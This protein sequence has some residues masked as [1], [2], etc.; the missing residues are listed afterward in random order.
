MIHRGLSMTINEEIV[1]AD[2]ITEDDGL[3]FS[4]LLDGNGG[5]S[6]V[7][8][9]VVEHWTAEQG[10]IWIHLD[11]MSPR[12]VNWL[13]ELSGLTKITCD[14][15]L[16]EETRPRVFQGKR[17]FVAILRGVNLNLDANLEDLITLRLWSDGQ[18]VISVRRERLQTP[19]D[20][21]AQLLELHSGPSTASELYERLI[22]RLNERM[23]VATG[24]IGER[25]DEFE[26]TGDTKSAADSRREIADLRSQILFLRRYMAPQRAA[27]HQLYLEPPRWLEE[28]SRL[29]LREASDSM[30]RYV[31]DLDMSRERATVI[32]DDIAS[33]LSESLNKN[34]YMLSIITALFLPISFGTGLL[35]INVGGMPGTDNSAAFWI[36][37]AAM[38]MIATLELIVFRR[39][40]WL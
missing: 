14:A 38:L 4:V 20:V 36:V 24:L 15:M 33:R 28:Q 13:R 6:L 35:G 7:D 3:I 26:A 40:K 12:A 17:G 9:Q 10:P 11:L 31:E 30:Q 29:R 32:K 5:A 23:S 39:L 27:L 18:R 1:K 16:V 21:L 25:I 2:E 22:T 8:W 19:R 37:C 34:L